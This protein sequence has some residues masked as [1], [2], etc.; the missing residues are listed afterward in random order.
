MKMKMAVAC[1]LLLSFAA[2]ADDYL[3]MKTT[4]GGFQIPSMARYESCKIYAG[5]TAGHY[6]VVIDRQYGELSA[7]QTEYILAENLE[8]Q[9]EDASNEPVNT[10]PNPICDAPETTYKA[11]IPAEIAPFT[12]FNTGGCGMPETD[13]QG[14]FSSNLESLI[15]NFCPWTIDMDLPSLL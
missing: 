5:K 15:D 13:R 14:P 7:R 2:G 8:S 6:R 12:L 1:G 10:T 11:Q 4:G 9:I 3:L